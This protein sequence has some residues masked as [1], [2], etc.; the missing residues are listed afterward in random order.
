MSKQVSTNTIIIHGKQW[1]WKT[2]FAV[3]LATDYI[4][5]IYWNVWIQ[6]LWKNLT[7][8]INSITNLEHFKYENKQ[9][10]ILFDEMW[11]NFNSKNHSTKRNQE[12]SKFFFLVRKYNLSS[13]F[14]SQRFNSVP[15]D[16]RELCDLIYEINP[17]H[18]KG[19]YPLFQ[20]TRQTFQSTDEWWHLE[21]E[22]E[23]VFDI[24]KALDEMWITYDSLESSI[25]D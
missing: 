19:T 1:W 11:L 16:M 17:I 22:E 23:Y 21:Y 25:I 24:I 15:V 13:I 5:R 4:W 18:R 20:I 9:W 14:V 2:I 6:E 10:C 8:R 7:C 3:L 12:L